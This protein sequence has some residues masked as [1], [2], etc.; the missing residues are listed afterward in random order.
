MRDEELLAVLGKRGRTEGQ[1]D[2]WLEWAKQVVESAPIDKFGQVNDKDASAYLCRIL[3][4]LLDVDGRFAYEK[5]VDLE[6]VR[7]AFCSGLAMCRCSNQTGP[8]Y[9]YQ[10]GLDWCRLSGLMRFDTEDR[11]RPGMRS[12]S[13][14]TDVVFLTPAG[15]ACA[16]P[17][18]A[19]GAYPGCAPD[20]DL[21]TE[22]ATGAVDAAGSEVSAELARDADGIPAAPTSSPSSPQPPEAAKPDDA[23]FYLSA[24]YDEAMFNH[25]PGSLGRVVGDPNYYPVDSGTLYFFKVQAEPVAQRL[26]RLFDRGVKPFAEQEGETRLRV[27]FSCQAAD[28][29]DEDEAFL[30]EEAID[31]A[32]AEVERLDHE[33]QLENAS[34]SVSSPVRKRRP[35]AGDLLSSPR[36]FDQAQRWSEKLGGNTATPTGSADT[37]QPPSSDEGPGTTDEPA[38]DEVLRVALPTAV[39]AAAGLR[40]LIRVRT[41]YPDVIPEAEAKSLHE[42]LV[43]QLKHAAEICRLSPVLEDTEIPAAD[44]IGSDVA[45]S[46]IMGFLA[47]H[48]P[49]VQVASPSIDNAAQRMDVALAKHDVFDP[50]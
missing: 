39:V 32:R 35:L 29:V 17:Q 27:W 49:D 45:V 20:V 12:G 11:W 31:A 21:Q 6:S 4:L 3:Y 33:W 40:D 46:L 7:L 9:L 44:A 14:M 23:W 34:G 42:Q 16:F 22:A 18:P 36:L 8:G 15:F 28:S 2:E 41:L 26:V 47:L 30:I 50:V 38:S 24:R 10:R 25:D 5:C 43:E 37:E 13:G 48:H 19:A 1:T